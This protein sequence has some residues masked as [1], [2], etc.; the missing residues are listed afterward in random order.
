MSLATVKKLDKHTRAGVL[1]DV[2]RR[3][4]PS[5]DDLS[6]TL[7]RGDEDRV[8][9]EISSK[10]SGAFRGRDEAYLPLVHRMLFNELRASVYGN[11]E[12]KNVRERVGQ[13][14]LLRTD[15]YDIKFNESFL[16]RS[17][18]MGVSKDIATQIIS[19]PL[20]VEHIFP[21]KE[22]LT[23]VDSHSLFTGFHPS[24]PGSLV[25]VLAIRKLATLSVNGAWLMFLED[26]NLAEPLPPVAMLKAFANFYGVMLRA[27][28]SES[29]FIYQTSVPM[30][31]GEQQFVIEWTN[32]TGGAIDTRFSFAAGMGQANIALAFAIE[33]ERYLA[34]LKKRKVR[35][36][37]V[38]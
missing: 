36:T 8:V 19:H 10:F 2:S 37:R 12:I 31:I 11:S 21:E 25:V 4:L 14:G 23:Q 9:D 1:A 29:R 17:A 3:Y 13:K 24:Y 38:I 6:F 15:L 7:G 27:G 28:E 18:K 32:P 35:I 30:K 26:M 34:D 33:V 5:V 22:G 20:A 16:S